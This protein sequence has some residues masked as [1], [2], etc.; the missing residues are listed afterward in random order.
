MQA[1]T[2]TKTIYVRRTFKPESQKRLSDDEKQ[3]KPDNQYNKNLN[4]DV[5]I[6]YVIEATNEAHIVAQKL[7][8]HSRITLH[9]RSDDLKYIIYYI[10]V[11]E[12][13]RQVNCVHLENNAV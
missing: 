5:D 4:I 7:V 11:Y 9:N 13:F 10:I 1:E 2:I 8:D 12:Y 6:V 3:D